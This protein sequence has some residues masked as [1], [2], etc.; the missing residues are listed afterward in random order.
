MPGAPDSPW[1][2]IVGIGEDGPDGLSSAARAALDEAALIMGAPRHL[3]LL[4]A[5][6]AETLTWPVPFET[7]TQ[8]LLSRRGQPTV[9]LASGDPFWFGAGASITR[10]LEPQEWI[11]HPAPS[12]FTLA[13]ARLGWPLQHVECHGLHA[14]PLTRLRPSL[15]PGRRAILLLRDGAAVGELAAWLTEQGFGASTLHVLEALGGPRERIR[16]CTAEMPNLTDIAHPVAVGL[17]LAGEGRTLPRSSGI[18]DDWFDHDGQI[19]KRPAR[20]LTLSALAPHPYETLWDI[21]AGSGSVAIEWLLAHPS[22]AAIAFEA[23]PERAARAR[24]NAL[25]LGADRLTVIEGRAPDILNGRTRPDA[26]F[27]GGGLSQSLLETLFALPGGPTR[28]VANAVTLESEALLAQ[29]HADEGGDLLRIE[30]AQA[31]PLGTRRGWRAAYPL[32][33]WSITL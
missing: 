7:G 1:L 23:D 9:M 14:A 13:A 17:T 26:I 20:A 32:V 10:H 6:R 27:I 15:A 5:L 28:L 19:T 8:M 3:A 21:G 4:P 24:A 22:T 30:L 12:A 33:Q 18:P 2:T 25:A 11:A 29:W 16:Q 31:T